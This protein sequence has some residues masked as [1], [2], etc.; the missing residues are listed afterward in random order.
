V[1]VV[2]R[3]LHSDVAKCLL[4]HSSVVEDFRNSL[5]LVKQNAQKANDTYLAHIKQFEEQDALIISKRSLLDAAM[6]KMVSALEQSKELAEERLKEATIQHQQ[7]TDALEQQH[8]SAVDHTKMAFIKHRAKHESVLE[9]LRATLNG[10]HA[11]YA[12]AQSHEAER[13]EKALQEQRAGAEGVLREVLASRTPRTL[14]TVVTQA[15]QLDDLELHELKKVVQRE[16]FRRERAEGA[17][18]VRLCDICYDHDRDTIFACGH[19]ACGQCADGLQN[20]HLC[21][22]LITSRGPVFM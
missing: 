18:E 16:Q 12:V 14:A 17:A 10:V 6:E 11:K 21:Q 2:R 15:M 8:K 1:D 3:L 20:C 4:H 22:A 13:H 7:A 19:L 9:D 5:E